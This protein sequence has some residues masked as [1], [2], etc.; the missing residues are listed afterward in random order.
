MH[1]LVRHRRREQSR[2][3]TRHREVGLVDERPYAD[4]ARTAPA[5]LDA[6]RVFAGL[7]QDCAIRKD[8][9]VLF[10]GPG[11]AEAIHAPI[12]MSKSNFCRRR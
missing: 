12:I 8:V 10:T 1:A 4:I 7:L 9:P 2:F 3:A 5:L 6:A 11:E